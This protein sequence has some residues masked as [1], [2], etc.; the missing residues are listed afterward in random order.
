MNASL[1]GAM[2]RPISM[3]SDN[4]VRARSFGNTTVPT[5]P[6]IDVQGGAAGAALGFD[7]DT[8]HTTALRNQL[9]RHNRRVRMEIVVVEA[10][11][12]ILYEHA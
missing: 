12:T 7:R 10:E 9:L 2:L 8:E 4:K 6:P 11:P 5:S 1:T 3:P